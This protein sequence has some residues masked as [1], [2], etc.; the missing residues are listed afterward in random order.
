MTLPL[1]LR[2]SSST[3]STVRRDLVV[4]EAL[5]H[6]GLQVFGVDVGARLD[7]RLELF[8]VALVGHA[9]HRAVDDGGMREEHLLDLARVDVHA[10]A[11]H[12]VGRTVGEEQVAV[13]V[14]V[15]DVA[16]GERAVAPRLL[17]LLG[18]RRGSGSAR[19]PAAGC[20][21]SRRARRGTVPV[22]VDDPDL[23][24]GPRQPD[25]P[26]PC[27]PLARTDAR[28]AAFARAV[29]LPDLGGRQRGDD[30]SLHV[31]PGTAPRRARSS[32][33]STGRTSPRSSSG[34]SRMRMKCAGVMKLSVT[35][36]ASTSRSHSR[37][38][39]RED[40]RRRADE[41]R[42]HDVAARDRRG[43]RG[44]TAGTRL[45]GA[46][47]TVR[48]GPAAPCFARSSVERAVHDALGPAGRA[49]RV[50]DGWC[51][52]LARDERRVVRRPGF[53]ERVDE[54]EVVDEHLG[55][56]SRSTMYATS[57]GLRCVFTSTTERLQLRGGRP[58]LE[59]RDRVRAA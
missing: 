9:E 48:P 7:H 27:E 3:S 16:D 52:H 33:G 12:H 20:R 28:R 55:L 51:E 49:R 5:L 23:D 29:Q 43:T 25:T 11:D 39:M 24:A 17:G 34:T 31:R 18:R 50:E 10:A 58:H 53:D 15:A 35:R 22:V 46:S 8:A 42:R 47:P 44:P 54:I 6:E 19:H 4:R 21:S 57:S 30:P 36:C 45:R 40:H 1:G 13:V 56:R 2:G 14:E 38:P 26:G 32:A 37:R 41:Q 59:E